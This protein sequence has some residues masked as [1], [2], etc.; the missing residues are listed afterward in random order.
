M[1]VP[2]RIRAYRSDDAVATMAGDMPSVVGFIDIDDT[3]YMDMLFVDPTVARHGVASRLLDHVER[4]AAGG[5]IARL[6]VH[7]SITARP[8]FLRHG[9][10]TVAARHPHIGEV[11]F[12]NYLMARETR[13]PGL[14]SENPGN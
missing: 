9:F 11:T 1:M 3:G 8:F 2:V 10:R 5:G 6:S 12:V 7:A 13:F 14:R 4:Y